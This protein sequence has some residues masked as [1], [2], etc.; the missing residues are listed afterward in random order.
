MDFCLVV[1][2]KRLGVRPVG[3]RKTIR[4][5]LAKLIMRTAGDHE[6]TACDNINL[7]AGFEAV[8]EG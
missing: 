2:D 4:R 8:I 7:C 5:D 6:K 1:L 3:I